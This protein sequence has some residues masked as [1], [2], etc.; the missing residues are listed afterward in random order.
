MGTKVTVTGMIA[1]PVLRYTPQNKAV[2]E[3]SVNGTRSQRDKTTGQW[4]D[5]GAPLWVAATFWEDEAQRLADALHKGDQVTVSGDLVLEEY[6]KRDGTPGQ[7]H[8]LRFPRFLGVVPRRQNTAYGSQ[9]A[10]TAS[11]GT[12]ANDPWGS[13][14]PA[15]QNG[16]QATDQWGGPSNVA[17]F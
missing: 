15:P 16:T 9:Q 8:V 6:Q 5:D 13:N 10:N 17:P 1:E 4:S 11:F 2:L 12:P 7:K 3:V 14:P